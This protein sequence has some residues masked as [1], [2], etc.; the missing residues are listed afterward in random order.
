MKTAEEI[1]KQIEMDYA[2][3]AP[4]TYRFGDL[5]IRAAKEAQH[6]PEFAPEGVPDKYRDLW[7]ENVPRVSS[8]MYFAI[9]GEQPIHVDDE[10]AHHILAYLSEQNQGEL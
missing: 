8:C 7:D 5:L 6:E 9:P 4:E 2:F 10:Q 3:R 1:A